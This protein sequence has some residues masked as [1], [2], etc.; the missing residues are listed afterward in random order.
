MMLAYQILPHLTSL[1]TFSCSYMY[2]E[3]TKLSITEPSSYFAGFAALNKE[4]CNPD[5][6][7][8]N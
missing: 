4:P 8:F 1:D 7:L 3:G 2:H 5:Q 6:V